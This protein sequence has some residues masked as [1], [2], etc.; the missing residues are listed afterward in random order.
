L[1]VAALT[2]CT[3]TGVTDGETVVTAPETEPVTV[4]PG[5]A[6]AGEDAAIEPAPT[7]APEAAEP[8]VEPEATEPEAYLLP[9]GVVFHF[10]ESV[11][12]TEHGA[13]REGI[14]TANEYFQEHFSAEI[15]DATVFVEPDV[16]ALASHYVDWL[17]LQPDATIGG[18][19]GAVAGPGAVFL[20]LSLWRDL[21]DQYAQLETLA[22]EW[23]H[24]L[25]YD[26]VDAP[27]DRTSTTTERGQVPPYGPA[28]LFEGAATYV[29][30]LVRAQVSGDDVEEMVQ[31]QTSL[32][33]QIPEPLANVETH[34]GIFEAGMGYA[35]L[36]ARS[37]QGRGRYCA[38]VTEAV[39]VRGSGSAPI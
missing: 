22:H 30:F 36:P 19:E 35:L 32:S 4:E 13:I 1:I 24:V 21:D 2:G 37:A 14:A 34:E 16:D 23:F 28:W 17:G 18:L 29:Q 12:D 5:E 31:R 3:D 6:V 15:T 20:N 27:R 25:Q 26:L 7:A 33:A 10:A 38:T 11:T 9:D 39:T 8:E